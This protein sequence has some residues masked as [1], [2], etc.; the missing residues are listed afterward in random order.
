MEAQMGKTETVIWCKKKKKKTVYNLFKLS[1][2]HFLPMKCL[3][4]VLFA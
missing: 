3:K 2:L 4:S 1:S